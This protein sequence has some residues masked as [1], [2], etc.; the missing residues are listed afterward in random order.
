[1]TREQWISLFGTLLK[2]VGGALVAKGVV[3]ADSWSFLSGPGAIE[4]YVGVATMVAPI[5]NDMIIHSIS[6]RTA[7]AKTLP[8]AE[9][10]QVA[11]TLSDNSKVR[12]VEA[13][14]DVKSIVMKPSAA[15]GLAAA[16]LDQGRPKIVAQS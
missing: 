6:G 3:T 1:M 9:K 5:I 2:A 10:I 11:D 12:L 4:F 15:D 7:A 13:L 14:P 16:V 8:A